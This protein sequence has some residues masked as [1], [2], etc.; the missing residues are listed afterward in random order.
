M[1]ANKQVEIIVPKYK[2]NWNYTIYIRKK[3]KRPTL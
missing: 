1:N 2:S 3:K